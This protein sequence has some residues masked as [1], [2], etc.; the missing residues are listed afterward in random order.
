MCSH[1]SVSNKQPH[2]VSVKQPYASASGVRRL[3]SQLFRL[4]VGPVLGDIRRELEVFPELIATHFGPLLKDFAPVRDVLSEL[5][6]G[7]AP[8]KT[9]GV[10]GLEVFAD[11]GAD[12]LAEAELRERAAARARAAA[13]TRERVSGWD[14]TGVGVGGSR[15]PRVDEDQPLDTDDDGFHRAQRS[16][17]AGGPL[18][19]LWLSG[20]SNRSCISRSCQY[21]GIFG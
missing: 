17:R 1:S 3:V 15:L 6:L 8:L 14:M 4:K 20:R 2:G 16:G 12:E 19:G 13:A 18:G 10:P 21:L 9:H 7:P 5:V 11:D